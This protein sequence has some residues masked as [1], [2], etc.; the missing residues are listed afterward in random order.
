MLLYPERVG[1]RCYRWW[2]VAGGWRGKGTGRVEYLFVCNQTACY[3]H[4]HTLYNVQCVSIRS[5]FNLV[6][7]QGRRGA[8]GRGAGRDVD[9]MMPG[10]LSGGEPVDPLA[11]GGRLNSMA[12]RNKK[13]NRIGRTEQFNS[14]SGGGQW[15][16]VLP[17]SVL[18][19][20]VW[21][22]E[23]SLPELMRWTVL[24]WSVASAAGWLASWLALAAWA[25]AGAAWGLRARGAER[26]REGERG[27]G[28]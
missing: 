14:G 27:I 1:N 17:W 11:P 28:R 25:S 26:G 4:I 24:P 20:E 8:G 13:P 10:G 19:S 5:C 16:T 23:S 12:G 22:D 7:P 21:C 18:P 3:W 15:W 2:V 9:S 6:G